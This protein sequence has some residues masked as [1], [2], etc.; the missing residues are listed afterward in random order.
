MSTLETDRRRHTGT[1]V[2][3][4]GLLIGGALCG[5]ATFV[6]DTGILWLHSTGCGPGPAD[7][8]QVREG[9]LWMGV[10]L[11][12]AIGFWVLVWWAL[13]RHR[14]AVVAGAAI[15]I[16]PAVGCLAYGMDAGSWIGGF[17]VPF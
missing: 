8:E 11:A 17:C 15:G 2:A 7:P 6:L 13:R 16:V 14:T 4:I 10:V 12:S 9:R 1:V 3:W 5:A